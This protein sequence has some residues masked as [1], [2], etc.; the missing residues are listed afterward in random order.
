MPILIKGS[1][2]AQKAPTISVS[3][4]GLITATAGKKSTTQQI[5]FS[6]RGLGSTERYDEKDTEYICVDLDN[7][8]ITI[9]PNR[10]A[11]GFG[12]PMIT[13]V[14]SLC[15]RIF[16]NGDPYHELTLGM[17]GSGTG[18][19]RWLYGRWEGNATVSKASDYHVDRGYFE[20]SY[21]SANGVFTITGCD[22]L[23]NLTEGEFTLDANVTWEL[24]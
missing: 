13:G 21:D 20:T 4:S 1:G 22:A 7:E 14:D 5:D 18:G 2:G 12:L 9:K 19:K 16:E 17:C 11:E 3:T 6:E 23:S 24:E 15:I 10:T 8:T